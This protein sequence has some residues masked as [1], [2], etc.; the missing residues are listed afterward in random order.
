MPS[1]D[2]QRVIF[3]SNWSTFCSTGCGT[4]SDIKDYV[5]GISGTVTPP[6]LDIIAPAAITDLHVK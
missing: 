3:A 6:P 5:V 4:T 1:R 2:G